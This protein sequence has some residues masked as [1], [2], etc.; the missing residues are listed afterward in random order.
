[1]VEGPRT[2]LVVDDDEGIRDAL[3]AVLDRRQ[4]RVLRASTSRHGVAVIRSIH[5]DMIVVDLTMLDRDGFRF[6]DGRAQ[7][8]D[9]AVLPAIA[10]APRRD[11]TIDEDPR[12]QAVVRWPAPL[13]EL[14]QTIVAWAA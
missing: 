3:R 10:V 4:F 2:V 8:P 9:L 11:A 13:G 5:V 12:V 1:M 7:I 6:L 14:V